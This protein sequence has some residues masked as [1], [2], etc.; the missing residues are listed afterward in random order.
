[1]RHLAAAEENRRLHLVAVLE[2]ALDVLL[3]ELVV[4]L[5]D[6]RP[7]LDLF[8]ED[9]LLVLLRLARAL[10]F[11]VLILPEIHDAADRRHGRRRDLDQVEP[12]LLRNR[13]RLRRR[14]DAELLAGVVDH[15]DFAHANA[16]VD[17]HAIVAAGTSIECDKASYLN[18][19]RT[20]RRS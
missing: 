11:L 16:L 19:N 1:M 5:V 12:L 2:E 15:P 20:W 14:H 3:L 7:E 6:L 10:L 13:E 4:V 17:P 8:D 18:T 9:H